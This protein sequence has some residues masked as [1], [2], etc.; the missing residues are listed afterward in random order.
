MREYI[1]V[2]PLCNL[3]QLIDRVYVPPYSPDLNLSEYIW[4][5]IKRIVT[6][7]FIQDLDPF[8]ESIESSFKQSG[9]SSRVCKKIDREVPE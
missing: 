1:K 4:K 6:V 2:E 5:R 8:K 9:C 7:A 3:L